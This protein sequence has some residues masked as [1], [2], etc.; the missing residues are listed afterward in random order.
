MRVKLSP[1]AGALGIVVVFAGAGTVI[2]VEK[3]H[4]HSGAT[5]TSPAGWHGGVVTLAP[6]PP[7]PSPSPRPVPLPAGI[8]LVWRTVPADDSLIEA[9][10]W[11]G[12]VRG[13]LALPAP[14]NQLS[15]S[16]SPDGQRLLIVTGDGTQDVLSAQGQ[17]LGQLP[18]DAGGTRFSWADDDVHLCGVR[19]GPAP[20]TSAQLVVSSLGGAERTVTSLHWPEGNG[21]ADL[22]ACSIKNDVAVISVGL[23]D[24]AAGHVVEYKVVRLST[25]ATVRD[26][27]PPEPDFTGSEPRPVPGALSYV[28]ASQDGRLLALVPYTANITDQAVAIAVVDAVSGRVLRAVTSSS[29][30]FTGDDSAIV[31]DTARV[32]MK[33]GRS[34]PLPGRC[35][36]GVATI[37]PG[38]R[39]FIVSVP[40]GA[41]PTP[42]TP[43]VQAQELPVDYVLWRADGTTVRIACCG[44][45]IIS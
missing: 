5:S 13:R 40:N 30:S 9:M 29:V 33:T 39:E 44:V 11:S 8:D 26:V 12:T 41:P 38:A 20:Y 45:T 15:L 28:T 4:G 24:D 16:L 1:L 21:G 22:R 31:T 34:T 27:H 32:E 6:D 42:G 36:G 25:G 3:H 37:R 35:C 19:S 17:E 14:Q 2:A 7:S 18:K 10:D 43:A 23:G